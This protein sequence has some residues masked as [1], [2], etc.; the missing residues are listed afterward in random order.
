MIH[1]SEGTLQALLDGE[2]PDA[3]R[4][5]LERHLRDCAA[6]RTELDALRHD[7]DELAEA[8]RLLDRPARVAAAYRDVTAK[9]RRNAAVVALRRAAVFLLFAAT[10]AAATIPGWPLRAWASEAWERVASA[11]APERA[12]VTAPVRVAAPEPRPEPV[13]T[14]I[15]LIPTGD[16][17]RVVIAYDAGRPRVRVRLHGE[18]RVEVR[19]TSS[20]G[21]PRFRTGPDRVEVRGKGTGE[22]WITVP[23]AGALT[24]DVNGQTYLAKRGDQLR[25]P[26]PQAEATETEIL[27]GARS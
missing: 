26:G 25:F 10:A 19:A 3:P 11:L 2:L 16:A 8:L 4:A 20:R 12:P 5:E 17:V 9:H 27:F 1:A 7:S 18:R 13:P 14:G 23:R 15:S 6:C 24:L 22:V 21:T